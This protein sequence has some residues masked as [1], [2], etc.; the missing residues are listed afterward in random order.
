MI[1][2]PFCLHAARRHPVVTALLILLAAVLLIAAKLRQS[3]FQQ[4]ASLAA[5]LFCVVMIDT[6]VWL[7]GKSGEPFP[8]RAPALESA[9]VVTSLAL[10]FAAMAQSLVPAVLLHTTKFVWAGSLG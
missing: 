6:V 1:G 3:L 9:A 4:I 10:S 8:V 7:L 5:V 2:C